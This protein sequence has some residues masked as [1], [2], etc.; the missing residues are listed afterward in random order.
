MLTDL[1]TNND[2]ARLERAYLSQLYREHELN[3]IEN[4]FNGIT[5]QLTE[6]INS[7]NQHSSKTVKNA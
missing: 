6:L 2:T 1:I 5:A 3:R 4:V 7:M